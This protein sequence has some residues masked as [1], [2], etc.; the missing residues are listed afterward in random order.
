VR[1][2]TQ[3]VTYTVTAKDGSAA[4]YTVIARLESPEPLLE[5]TGFDDWYT[6]AGRQ[7]QEPGIDSSGIW[8]TAK[9][10]VTTFPLPQSNANTLPLLISGTDYAAK[11][12]TRQL[13]GFALAAG[14]GIGSATLF[15]GIFRVNVSNP[16]AS[17][18]MG[19]PF[20]ARPTTFTVDIKYEAGSP[21]L[22]GR[23]QTLN[24]IDSADIYVLLE[25]RQ[26]QN[27][28]R[29]IATGWH[30]T[31]TTAGSQFNSISVPLIYGRLPAG[32]PGHQFPDNGLFGNTSDRI[33]DIS[34]VFASSSG[35]EIFE[36]GVG[37]TLT[38]NNF[39]LVY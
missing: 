31:G 21:F 6:P 2:F 12:I 37:S 27:N 4:I 32:T 23:H 11:L 3:P 14:Q 33:T 26:D 38:V 19:Y 29:R 7:F 39:R 36:G 1:D 20:T 13:G 34:V 18:Q 16:P 35:G 24:K 9:T 28:I 17:A 10:G 30:R 15:T 5:N 25:N 22:N 8:A